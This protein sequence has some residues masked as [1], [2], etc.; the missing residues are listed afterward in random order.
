MT[1]FLSLTVA[2]RILHSKKLAKHYCE[3]AKQLLNCF[4]EE[5]KLIYSKR[6]IVYNVHTLLH[7]V[8]FS[9]LND[10]LFSFSAYRFENNMS[11]IKRCIRGTGN[12]INQIANRL[13][14][15]RQ[16]RLQKKQPIKVKLISKM[17]YEIELNQFCIL[18][19]E[20]K[21]HSLVEVFE[22]TAAMFMKPCDSRLV[23]IFKGYLSKTTMKFVPNH[24]LASF[25][26]CIP[27]THVSKELSNEGRSMF[28]KF[29]QTLSLFL[30]FRRRHWSSCWVPAYV[31][32][33]VNNRVDKS[34][35][36]RSWLFIFQCIEFLLNPF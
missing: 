30:L 25:G 18:H 22:N 36:T 9:K 5:A 33:N 34:Y 1:H 28:Y 2:L 23:G 16:V 4:V 8:D 10:T 35:F 19:E 15:Q 3:Y 29:S 6:F 27:L 32:N 12:P 11:C 7:L 31:N 17:C 13:L 21:H 24:K 26:L 20:K 14:E